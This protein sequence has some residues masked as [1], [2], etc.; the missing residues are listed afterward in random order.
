MGDRGI[1]DVPLVSGSHS[2]MQRSIHCSA[3]LRN[4]IRD[5]VDLPGARI[6]AP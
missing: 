1:N 2:R 3:K 5:K 6:V 4:G